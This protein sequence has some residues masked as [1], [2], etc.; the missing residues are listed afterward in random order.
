MR[1]TDV[2]NLLVRSVFATQAERNVSGGGIYVD[3]VSAFY[4]IVREYILPC[5]SSDDAIAHMFMTLGLDHSTIYELADLLAEPTAFS[6]A[7]IP[8]LLSYAISTHFE[9]TYFDMT[10]CAQF[11]CAK[12]GTRPGHPFAD[13]IFKLFSR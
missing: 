12:V 3:I 4:S 13:L 2:A 7:G 5:S 6:Q 11:G 1:G 10:G 8:D 9:A